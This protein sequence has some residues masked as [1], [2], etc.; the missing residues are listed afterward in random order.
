MRPTRSVRSTCGHERPCVVEL[1]ARVQDLAHEV[2]SIHPSFEAEARLQREHVVALVEA[3]HH[4]AVERLVARAV[5]ATEVESVVLT[6]SRYRRDQ[7]REPEPRSRAS[8]VHRNRND[9][10]SHAKAA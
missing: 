7:C 9:K 2:E 10:R 6:E 4:L 1:G 3:G 5:G 8:C